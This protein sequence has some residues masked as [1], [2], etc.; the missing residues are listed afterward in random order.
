MPR[1]AAPF[2]CQACGARTRQFFGRCS[3]CGGWNTLVEEVVER[4]EC[5]R[6]VVAADAFVNVGS[7]SRRL[8]CCCHDCQCGRVQKAAQEEEPKV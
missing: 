7:D 2:V 3:A 6:F 5:R 4:D 1:S 8:C